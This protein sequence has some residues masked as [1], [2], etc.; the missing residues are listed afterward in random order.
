VTDQTTEPI[1]KSLLPS[2]PP[3]EWEFSSAFPT[4]PEGEPGLLLVPG[5]MGKTVVRRQV[6]YGDWEPVRPGHWAAEPLS[7][8]DAI[9]EWNEYDDERDREKGGEQPTE[10]HRLALSQALGL[11]TGAPWDAILERAAELHRGAV[12]R[13]QMA[14]AVTER[15]M[16]QG[17]A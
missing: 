16:P 15:F 3:P 9:A 17:E 6:S 13:Q 1:R 4:G 2:T 12:K 11:G 8:N 7:L 14:A 5:D 10:D